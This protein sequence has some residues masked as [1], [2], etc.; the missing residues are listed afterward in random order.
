MEEGEKGR[1]RRY[2][3]NRGRRKGGKERKEGGKEEERKVWEM[4]I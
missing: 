3:K 1:E 2:R 4:Q